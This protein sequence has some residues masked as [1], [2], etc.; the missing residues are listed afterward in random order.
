[1]Q[2]GTSSLLS[3]ASV[4]FVSAACVSTPFQDDA[5]L[6]TGE[7]E[8][9]GPCVV[10]GASSFLATEGFVAPVGEGN[11]P[12]AT[13][14]IC[15]FNHREYDG[16]PTFDSWEGNTTLINGGSTA[17]SLTY[18]LGEDEEGNAVPFDNRGVVVGVVGELGYF[19][20]T[21]ESA[22]GTVVLDL[23][24]AAELP[25]TRT[26]YTVFVGITDLG[27]PADVI[28]AGEFQEIPIDVTTVNSG[29]L[30]VSLSWNTSA[31]MDLYVTEPDG[32]RIF[33]GATESESGGTLD[34]DGNA[35]CETADERNEN[36]YWPQG[37]ASSGEYIVEV[38][39]FDPCE[40]ASGTDW[41]VTVLENGV[42]T[43]HTGSVDASDLDVVNVTTIDWAGP[44]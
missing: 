31:D 33:W 26:R 24:I 19:H 6:R 8:G 43:V 25:T 17:I 10:G 44:Q 23:H 29:E 39:Q 14:Y 11:T 41:R 42:P 21:L 13:H 32:T 30:Q 7:R 15:E 22:E 1:M 18:D 9:A 37:S 28:T 27:A 12:G 2:R 38:V 20:R 40:A 34:L 5:F 3:F 16:R 35:A 36:I 4:A